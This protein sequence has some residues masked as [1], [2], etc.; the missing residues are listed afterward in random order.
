MTH[1][2]PYEIL[3]KLATG[4][5]ADICL[6][7][8]PPG[9]VIVV[10]KKLRSD[11]VSSKDFERMF[12]AECDT[13]SRLTH[14]NIVRT[15]E[16]GVTS[17]GPYLVMEYLRG[18]DLRSLQARLGAAG[19]RL[20]VCA[21][22]RIGVQMCAGLHYAHRAVDA[23]G[24]P[25]NVVHR[26]V[27]P[28]NVFLTTSGDVKLVDF[29]IA[30]S[31]IRSWETKHGTIKGKVPYMAPE[32]VKNEPVDARTDVYAA[33]VVLYEL[34]TGRRPY[35]ARRSAEFAMM[36]AIARHDVARPST[37]SP[38]FPPV[39]EEILL[40]ALALEP[41]A[42]F[43]SAAE[44]GAALEAYAH[45]VGLAL[46][47]Q[48]LVSLVRDAGQAVAAGMNEVIGS[49]RSSEQVAPEPQAVALDHVAGVAVLSLDAT[50][51][52]DFAGA[53]VGAA[54]DGVVILDAS[55]VVRVTSFGVRE[56]LHMMR[57]VPSEAELYL[58]G[59]SPA[60]AAQMA[61]VRGFVGAA[62]IISVLAP[63]LCRDC[64][65][66]WL[67]AIDCE[68]DAEQIL[69]G[70]AP[71]VCDRC[72]GV[73]RFDE[74]EDYLAFAREH[75]GRPAL[76]RVVRQAAAKLDAQYAS[77]GG[78]IEKTVDIA[79]TRVRIHGTAARKPRWNK[80]LDGVEGQLVLE[81]NGV[82]MEMANG[83]A[84]A[85]ALRALPEVSRVT[86]SDCPPELAL[87][88]T[89]EPLGAK[90]DI[91]TVARVNDC[92]GCGGVRLFA[93][94]GKEF[95]E[96]TRRSEPNWASCGRCGARVSFD[97]TGSTPEQGTAQAGTTPVRKRASGDARKV[98]ALLCTLLLLA[99]ALTLLGTRRGP[100]TARVLAPSDDT[101]PS[102]APGFVV[103]TGRGANEEEALA[104]AR[105]SALQQ[106]MARLRQ[107]VPGPAGA[108]L[109]A[110]PEGDGLGDAAVRRF[111]AQLTNL[112]VVERVDA[113]A[114]LLDA[115]VELRVRYRVRGEDYR[116]AVRHYASCTPVGG[117]TACGPFWTKDIDAP[118]LVAL[119]DRARALPGDA[120]AQV[121]GVA[122][123]DVD[124]LRAALRGPTHVLR[125][126]PD[127][128]AH[129]DLSLAELNP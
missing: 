103:G 99:G 106:V 89:S 6:A 85:A 105:R 87:L 54:L 109:R 10:L 125:V 30:K 35:A 122:V 65:A 71:S 94:D 68:R 11:H 75:V 32:Q 114:R 44:L 113:S 19:Q 67:R 20:P 74:H 96:R 50:I 42:R 95:L 112:N 116:N 121:D 69:N 14:P 83:A 81:L 63:Y 29:G 26:D 76:S 22:L 84:L 80:I 56:W 46:G 41:T 72:G 33:G 127:R 118:L 51:A 90:I 79:A 25:M 18:E 52:E 37:V 66:A 36:L 129:Y 5:M 77:S 8:R 23:E 88:M 102:A 48:A 38:G 97:V 120:V 60:V 55:Q 107:E 93:S 1:I 31:R 47:R 27:S 101:T 128:G 98:G 2:G 115:G 92:V 4:G 86:V 53:S 45:Q 40:R 43:A 58:Y 9:G 123:P 17:E 12:E 78:G 119:P 7:R 126:V 91:R 28:Q 124:A 111:D 61:M 59:V 110:L 3:G 104:A 57:A 82:D 70:P 62:R 117:A 21:A 108:Y 73:A 100:Q 13:S 24:E 49:G 15:L 64:G 39:L 16:H 34:L